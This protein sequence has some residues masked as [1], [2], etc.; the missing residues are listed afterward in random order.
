MITND[1]DLYENLQSRSF[2]DDDN[3]AEECQKKI[4]LIPAEKAKK[5]LKHLF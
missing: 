2:S 5:S 4:L 3:S 1:D